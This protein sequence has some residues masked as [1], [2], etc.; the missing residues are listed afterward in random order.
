MGW[1]RDILEEEMTQLVNDWYSIKLKNINK[2]SDFLNHR[3]GPDSGYDVFDIG[4]F[5][6]RTNILNKSV[7]K[8]R[9]RKIMN[10]Y[11]KCKKTPSSRVPIA[12]YPTWC[13]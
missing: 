2:V 11:V 3:F 10:R 8:P 7:Y 1:N 12:S 4:K 5:L 9:L 13:R 6:L